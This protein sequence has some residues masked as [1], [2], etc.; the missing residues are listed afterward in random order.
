MEIPRRP[1]LS[2]LLALIAS[3]GFARPFARIE[4][5]T[6]VAAPV[7]ACV[8]PYNGGNERL[9]VIVARYRMEQ[10]LSAEGVE[11]WERKRLVEEREQSGAW[12]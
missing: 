9:G 4:P 7:P 12:W 8:P 10:R 6:P 11:F 2:G 3:P 5:P 1:L